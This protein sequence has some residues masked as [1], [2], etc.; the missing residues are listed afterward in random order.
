MLKSKTYLFWT[1]EIWSS[2]QKQSRPKIDLEKL[3]AHYD[4]ILEVQDSR[5]ERQLS[6]A[7]LSVLFK[8]KNPNCVINIGPDEF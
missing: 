2:L 7:K 3:L 4:E 6:S 5:G 8:K 1:S